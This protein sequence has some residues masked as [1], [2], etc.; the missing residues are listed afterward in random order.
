VPSTTVST[1]GTTTVTITASSTASTPWWRNFRNLPQ[2]GL[3][4][5]ALAFMLAATAY[6]LRKQRFVYA[7]GAAAVL[8]CMLG[9]VSC[10][11]GGS[12]GSTSSGGGTTT[13]TTPAESGSVIVTATSGLIKN[14][15]G[16]VVT[17]PSHS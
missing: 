8:A 10:G 14:Q 12:S 6:L 15:V 4:L 2:A 7:W 16:I 3:G 5:L 11:G 17:V 13:T 9:A 1:S